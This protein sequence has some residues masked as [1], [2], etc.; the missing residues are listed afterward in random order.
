MGAGKTTVG[1]LL[2]AETE[3]AL[4][5]CDD[6]LTARTGRAAA[7]IAA[8]EG[9]DALHRLEAEVL[10]DALDG[11]AATVITAAASTIEDPRCR[12]AL[13]GAFVVWLRAEPG[14]LAQRAQEQEHRP[15]EHDDVEAQLA[16][17]AQRRNPLFATVADVVVDVDSVSPS[18]A[19]HAII[20]GAKLDAS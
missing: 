1:G 16:A 2:A 9:L 14:V 10:L 13:G 7:E 15:L 3:R 8:A 11:A 5:D 17:H 19:V 6:A 4:V 12:A 18:D 20:E